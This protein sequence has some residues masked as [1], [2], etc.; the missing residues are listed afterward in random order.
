MPCDDA[1]DRRAQRIPIER[2]IECHHGA[3]SV[4]RAGGVKRP[5]TSL[6]RRQAK[7]DVPYHVFIT[8]DTVRAPSLDTES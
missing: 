2:S 6:L 4:A 5:D 7:A 8:A 1:V 3:G